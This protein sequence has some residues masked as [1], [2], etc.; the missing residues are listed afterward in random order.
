MPIFDLFEHSE[1]HEVGTFYETQEVCQLLVFLDKARSEKKTK[2][3][4][5]VPA[6]TGR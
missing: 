4:I 2:K 6:Q 1:C 3:D 5:D